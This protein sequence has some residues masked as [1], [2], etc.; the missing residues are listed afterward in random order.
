MT[1]SVDTEKALDKIQF[2][3]LIKMP[4]MDLEI[5]VQSEVRQRQISYT[6]TYMWILKN[7]TSDIIYNTLKHI[8]NTFMVTKG[9][10]SGGG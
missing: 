6:I 1:T 9:G 8:G 3:F 4:K 5:I 10:K 2:S 7:D